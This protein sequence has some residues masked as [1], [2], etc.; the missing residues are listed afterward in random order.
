MEI[1]FKNVFIK[2]LM[3]EPK[4]TQPHNQ[5][6]KLGTHHLASD[7]DTYLAKSFDHYQFVYKLPFDIVHHHTNCYI[8]SNRTFPICIV[9]HN[10][11]H[12]DGTSVGSGFDCD[13]RDRSWCASVGSHSNSL[14]TQIE[15]ILHSH[16][17]HFVTESVKGDEK[18]IF[19][20]SQLL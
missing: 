19:F 11:D 20:F 1:S 14:Y 8:H 16:N 12:F 9:Y 15:P 17:V 13:Y 2:Y 3:N 5:H 6:Y 4:R 18:L 7:H 10:G